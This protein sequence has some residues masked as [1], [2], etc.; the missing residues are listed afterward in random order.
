L[1]VEAGRNGHDAMGPSGDYEVFSW[2]DIDALVERICAR[3]FT[4]ESR[5]EIDVP[6]AGEQLVLRPIDAIK[7]CAG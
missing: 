4:L 6:W 5:R 7:R 1:I 2:R 3:G